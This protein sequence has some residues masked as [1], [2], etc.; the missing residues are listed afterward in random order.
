MRKGNSRRVFPPVFKRFRD[1][2][3]LT[4]RSFEKEC[5]A[6]Q[7]DSKAYLDAMR[8]GYSHSPLVARVCV[9][10]VQCSDDGR[11]EPVG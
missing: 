10:E 3:P 1:N 6:L 5:L 8:G 9:T 7:K 11:A 4:P 2:G